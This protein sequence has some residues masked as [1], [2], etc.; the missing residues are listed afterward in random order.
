MLLLIEK[1]VPALMLLLETFGVKIYRQCAF[2]DVAMGC[3]NLLHTHTFPP[4]CPGATLF[5]NK[6]LNER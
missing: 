6:R 2:F 5:I 4:Y 1:V 3:L